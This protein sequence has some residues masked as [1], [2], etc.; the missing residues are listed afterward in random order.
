MGNAQADSREYMGIMSGWPQPMM[1]I[2]VGGE[3]VARVEGGMDSER[4]RMYSWQ[5]CGHMVS[6]S[7]GMFEQLYM[8][9]CAEPG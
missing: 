8:R 6:V 1:M 2:S 3:R 4:T 7:K 5:F 9:M